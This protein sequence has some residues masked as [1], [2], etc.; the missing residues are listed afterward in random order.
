[1]TI[2]LQYLHGTGGHQPLLWWKKKYFFLVIFWRALRR[3]YTTLGANAPEPRRP[4]YGRVLYRNLSRARYLT[5]SVIARPCV[6]ISSVHLPRAS[7]I[8]TRLVHHHHHHPYHHHRNQHNHHHHRHHRHHHPTS[9]TN[10][11]ATARA[12][13]C[14]EETRNILRPPPAAPLMWWRYHPLSIFPVPRIQQLCVGAIPSDPLPLA[15]RANWKWHRSTAAPSSPAVTRDPSTARQHPHTHQHLSS[16]AHATGAL[17]AG[18][19]SDDLNPCTNMIHTHI[20]IWA[21]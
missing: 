6:I 1:M 21:E 14:E 2:I 7:A 13:L 5:V 11:N 3:H 17:S 10:A 9:T 15:A 8:P 18:L 4:V 19:P 20:G 16:A 12:R